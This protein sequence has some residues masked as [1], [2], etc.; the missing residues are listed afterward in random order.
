MLAFRK[1]RK[2]SIKRD[3]QRVFPHYWIYITSTQGPKK[4]RKDR[5]YVYSVLTA[6]HS[7]FFP[8]VTQLRCHHSKH[9]DPAI[10]REMDGRLSITKAQTPTG[11]TFQFI[12]MYQFTAA[13]PQGQ[14]D[15]WTATENWI[16]K[17]K[18][19]RIILQGDLNSAHPGGRWD[20]AQ[21]LNKDIGTADKKL[22]HFIKS[23]NGN[24]YTQREHTWKGKDCRAALDHVLTW[25]YHLPPQVTRTLPESHKRFDHTNMDPTSSP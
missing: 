3:L 11:T 4:D 6:L 1:K 24:F 2:N 20:Y 23:T 19:N 12:N 15:M 17:Q 21:P 9:L 5:P 16:N 7:A 18:D 25:N 8:K 13:N 22:E 14:T 10:R